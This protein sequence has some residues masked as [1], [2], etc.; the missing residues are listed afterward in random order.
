MKYDGVVI[1]LDQLYLF[2][3]NPDTN[4]IMDGINISEHEC[5]K[6]MRKD[7][8]MV[9]NVSI[10]DGTKELDNIDLEEF[11]YGD[12][13]GKFDTFIYIHDIMLFSIGD[14]K[15]IDRNVSLEEIIKSGDLNKMALSC[16]ESAKTKIESDDN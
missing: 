11:I 5:Y 15:N 2:I 4:A 10:K 12:S 16:I 6:D 13:Y 1:N 14:K 3:L 9:V 8:L 7:Q